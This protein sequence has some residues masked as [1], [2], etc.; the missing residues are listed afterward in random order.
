MATEF[1]G[2]QGAR[3][4]ASIQTVF[5]G[6]Q[7]LSLEERRERMETGLGLDAQTLDGLT[8]VEGPRLESTL[9]TVEN[10]VG[11]FSLP[12][13]LGLPLKVNG[14]D[15]AIPMVVEEPSV[16]P[17]LSFVAKLVGEAGGFV[18]EADPSLMIGQ[19]QLTR[20]GPPSFAMARI[21]EAR[22]ELLALAN[23]MHPQLM[24]E[25]GGA[26]DVEVRLLP[27]P[28]GPGM[29]P[30]LVVHVLVDTKEAM[31]A[32]LVNTMME[33]IAPRIEQLTGGKV[34][35]RILTHLSDRRLARARCS[36][37]E[38]AL[39]DFGLGGVEVAEG[40]VQASRFAQADPYRAATHN[41][42]IMNGIDALALATGQDWRAL[43][44]GAHAFAARTGR[45]GPLSVW[46][47]E[48]GNLLGD[49]QLPLA[50]G[51]VG[52]TQRAHPGVQAALRVLGHPPARELACIFASVGLAQNL[53]AIRALGSAGNQRGH[54]ALQ[55]RSVATSVGAPP[56]WV[57]AIAALLVQEGEVRVDRARQVL[58][59]M[60]GGEGAPLEPPPPGARRQGEQV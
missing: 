53:A 58:D 48:G 46:R 34:Y 8:G 42:G 43:E 2:P 20:Y 10:A 31:G 28:E 45:Y 26:R 13:G 44:A 32:H 15:Y 36:I 12:L 4:D 18:A 40:I 60:R 47:R 51:T 21:L 11:L 39:A 19:I 1:V 6:F 33:G 59:R 41:K 37:P 22:A 49:I 38:R 24:E 54:M 50:L 29:E 52:D 7:C 30:L 14:R 55:A 57:E 9:S 23:A 5:S 3:G 27:A 16:I 35:L 17:A 56:E 25:G